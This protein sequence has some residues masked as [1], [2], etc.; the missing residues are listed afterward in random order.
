MVINGAW[1]KCSGTWDIEITIKLLSHTSRHCFFDE[2]SFRNTHTHTHTLLRMDQ[3]NND[4]WSLSINGR[5]Y[6]GADELQGIIYLLKGLR[7][8][9]EF[10]VYLHYFYSAINYVKNNNLCLLCHMLVGSG[11]CIYMFVCFCCNIQ[12]QEGEKYKRN[13]NPNF[14]KKK[15]NSSRT[16]K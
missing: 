8:A 3:W 7:R 6:R 14:N 5:K 16:I 13:K 15:K 11:D 9:S 4:V 2:V 10:P 12:K 1:I